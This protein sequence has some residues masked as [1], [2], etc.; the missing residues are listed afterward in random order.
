MGI[1]YSDMA[2][3]LITGEEL[4][5]IINNLGQPDIWV[6][7]PKLYENNFNTIKKAVDNLINSPDKTSV[8]QIINWA[9]DKKSKRTPLYLACEINPGYMRQFEIIE[10]LLSVRGIDINKYGYYNDINKERGSIKKLINNHFSNLKILPPG[11]TPLWIASSKGF[12]ETVKILLDNNANVNLYNYKVRTPLWIAA[13]NNHL[14]VIKLLLLTGADVNIADINGK[15]PINVASDAGRELIEEHNKKLIEEQTKIAKDIEEPPENPPGEQNKES[16]SELT[17]RKINALG[18]WKDETT[19]ALR[20]W[21]D[22]TIDAAVMSLPSLTA[23]GLEERREWLKKRREEQE[24]ERADV[25]KVKAALDDPR[26]DQTEKISR[27]DPFLN[28]LLGPVARWVAKR[29]AVSEMKRAKREEEAKDKRLARILEKQEK[30]DAIED[31]K[32][33]A[34]EAAAAEAAARRTRYKWTGGGSLKMKKSTRKSRRKNKTTLK[35]TTRKSR[36]KNKTTLKNATI[37]RSSKIK[38]L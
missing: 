18:K 10:L 2:T 4:W 21:N 28:P 32:E 31:K 34:A 14:E 36:R 27:L 15:T 17:K 33:A 1:I 16:W 38:F 11:Q 22:E 12:T 26:L 30:R 19:D 6:G 25:K 7:Q 29:K 3:K 9:N 35:N 37:N 8:A 20:K 24:M 5:H 23:K 13:R